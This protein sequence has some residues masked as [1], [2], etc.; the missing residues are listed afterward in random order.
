M[1]TCTATDIR[2]TWNVT[3]GPWVIGQLKRTAAGYEFTEARAMDVF[4]QGPFTDAK[5]AQAAIARWYEGQ[6]PLACD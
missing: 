6:Q 4:T 1:P 2:N 5:A 3:V